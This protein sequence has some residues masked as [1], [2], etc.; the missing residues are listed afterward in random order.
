[1]SKIILLKGLPA[2]GKSTKAKEILI[3][4]GNAVRLNKDLLRTM[5]HFDKFTGK[6]EGLTRS[7]QICLADYFMT[8]GKNVIIDDTNL[9]PKVVESWKDFAR[10]D[11]RKLEIVEM[12]VPWQECVIRDEYRAK[13]GERSVGKYVI[14]NLARKYGLYEFKKKEIICDMDGTLCDL[15][16]RLHLVKSGI[17]KKDWDGF[18]AQIK[19]DPPKLDTI[20]EID[21]LSKEFDIIIV[22]GRPDT[23]QKETVEWLEK[24]HVPFTTILMRKAGDTRPDDIVK[25]E[26]LDNYFKKD[27][28]EKVYDDRKRVIDMWKREGLNVIN[29]GGENNDF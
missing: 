29:C 2:S 23:Y 3:S 15:T 28:I 14:I 25:K 11:G 4:D 20:R 16:H 5:L 6:N 12:N 8:Q 27:M 19:S 9:N 10:H 1:M 13:M 22:S 17:E 21:G 7:A 26:I 18:F 24:Y